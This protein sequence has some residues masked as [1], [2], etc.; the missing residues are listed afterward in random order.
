MAKVIL[1]QQFLRK[2]RIGGCLI[3]R[4]WKGI[5]IVGKK[6]RYVYRNTTEQAKNRNRFARAVAS[7]Q[8]LDIMTQYLWRALA[9]GKEM[10]G[11]EY[12]I[13]KFVEDR[14]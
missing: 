4:V 8:S 9:Y 6:P 13:K 3:Y 11:Y 7:W 1:G 10:S 2:G 14:V 5:E 12:Y